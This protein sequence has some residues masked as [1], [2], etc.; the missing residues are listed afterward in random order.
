MKKENTYSLDEYLQKIATTKGKKYK[1]CCYC[2]IS[3][4]NLYEHLKKGSHVFACLENNCH[5]IST[6]IQNMKNHLFMHYCNRIFINFG[7]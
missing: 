1:I 2:G 5:F 3:V 4:E 7:K 6:T